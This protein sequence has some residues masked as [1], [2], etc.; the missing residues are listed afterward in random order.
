MVEDLT[1]GVVWNNCLDKFEEI[2]PDASPSLAAEKV[3]TRLIKMGV[4]RDKI[5]YHNN[6]YR[7]PLGNKRYIIHRSPTGIAIQPFTIYAGHKPRYLCVDPELLVDL[8]WQFDAVMPEIRQASQRIYEQYRK[9][10]IERE[11]KDIVRSFYE[12]TDDPDMDAIIKEHLMPL[13]IRVWYVFHDDDSTVSIDLLRDGHTG[14]CVIPQ[15][16]YKQKLTDREFILS[17]LDRHN[18]QTHITIP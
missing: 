10:E 3:V 1:V 9:E 8:I 13:G 2:R 17:L 4:S 18:T 6:V 11:I 7:V 12:R 16:Q 5:T 15:D 14:H